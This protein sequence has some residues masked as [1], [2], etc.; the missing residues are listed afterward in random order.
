MR[1]C[2]DFFEL[3]GKAV[4]LTSPMDMLPQGFEYLMSDR[5]LR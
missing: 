1:E 3:D 5:L 4:L 2:P